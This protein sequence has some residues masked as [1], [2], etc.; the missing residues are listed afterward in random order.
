MATWAIGDLQGCMSS[1]ERLLDRIAFDAGGDR[2]WLVGDLVNRGPRSLDVLRW[3][4]G[5]GD[6][7]VAVLGNHDL[8]LL[9]RIAGAA[10]PKKR[11]TLDAVLAAPDRDVL[12]DWLRR[13]PL[14]HVEGEH[15]MV[16]AGLHPR[17]SAKRARALAAEIEVGLTGDDW[18]TW[19]KQLSGKAQAWHDDLD[20]SERVRAIVQ[21]FARVRMIDKDGVPDLGYDGPPH[22][23]PRGLRPWFELADAKWSD[24]TAVFGHWSAMGLAVGPRHLGL[25]TGCVWG[26]RLTA[27]RLEDRMVVQVDAAEAA[28]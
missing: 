20:G 24:H 4:Q 7:V 25:D 14:V 3:A 15:L 21:F 10:E 9:A 26:R 6:A 19:I 16:H 1:L 27:V 11:D 23:A 13:R 8:H 12:G 18:R 22:Q 2:L 17:W 5:L 28:R